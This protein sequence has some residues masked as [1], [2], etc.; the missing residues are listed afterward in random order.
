MIFSISSAFAYCSEPSAPYG[1]TPSAPYCSDNVCESWTAD[2]FKSEV[3]NYLSKM[4]E[5]A[6]EAIGYAKCQK[7]EAIDEWNDFAR[8]NKVKR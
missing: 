3:E 6:E 2:S 1:G 7:E 8:N 4:N 5:Y